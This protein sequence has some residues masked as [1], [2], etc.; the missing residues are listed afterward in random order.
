MVNRQNKT[1]RPDQPLPDLNMTI[2]EAC[3]KY[4]SRDKPF[5]L[6]A[7]T[8]TTIE[9]GKALWPNANPS[10]SL[11]PSVLIFLKYFN[12]EAQ[13]LKGVGHIY[14]KKTSKVAEMI[15]A[16]QHLMGWSPSRDPASLSSESHSGL[17]S[18]PH[19]TA[20]TSL[21]L[22]EEIKHTMI[23]PLKA[24]ATLQQAEIQD[25]DIVCFQR[26]L[27]EKQAAEIASTG[28]YTDAREFYDYLANRIFV[29]F[30]PKIATEQEDGTFTLP[31][32][33]KMSY[34]QFSAKVGEHL[35][36]DPTHLR[37]TTILSSTGKPKA[38]VRRGQVATLQQVLVPAIGTYAASSQRPDALF[39]EILE[40]SI[41]ELETKRNIR[42]TW[43]PEGVTKEV[44]DPYPHCVARQFGLTFIL[45]SQL[46]FSP[47][48]MAQ[49][50]I[51]YRQ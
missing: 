10:P 17:P 2:T 4:S 7:E 23:E 49:S 25:G 3:S 33:K 22:Y 24:K 19:S 30:I 12:P 1:T 26:A 44:R 35:R 28:G 34:D 46:I 43:L 50:K 8:A 5:R 29:R 16:I 14:M 51:Y 27:S 36:V 45:R 21:C 9:D 41:S 31:L 20:R 38:P 18:P 6:W 11:P 15:P 48:K 37:F 40:M 47:P 42:V 39:Y 32:S 13:T